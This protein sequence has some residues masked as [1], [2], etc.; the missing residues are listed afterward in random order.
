M[1]DRISASISSSRASTTSCNDYHAGGEFLVRTDEKIL[2]E[3]GYVYNMAGKPQKELSLDKGIFQDHFNIEV[4]K[5]IIDNPKEADEFFK[6]YG[7]DNISIYDKFCYYEE[8]LKKLKDEI[9]DKISDD[10]YKNLHKGLPFYLLSCYAF[11]MR[12]YEKALFYLDAA[13]SEDIKNSE[14][15]KICDKNYQN[16]PAYLFITL[17]EQHEASAIVKKIRSFLLKKLKDMH[18]INKDD[19]LNSFIE[20]LIKE[21]TGE[22]GKRSIITAFY[23]FLLE[24]KDLKEQLELRSEQGGS[25]EPFLLHLF[26]GGLIMESLLKLKYKFMDN[27]KQIKTLGDIFNCCKVFK[28]DFNFTP[29]TS[30]VGLDVILATALSKTALEDAFS[31]TAKLRNTTGHKLFWDDIF[32]DP[33][34]YEILFDNELKAICYIILEKKP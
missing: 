12:N 33:K 7:R 15:K 24:Y 14:N 31:I 1:S 27:G 28:D 32:D 9:K 19:E 4:L 30:A 13:I 16:D 10:G 20:K 6:T 25:I 17:K 22:E 34:N 26:K 11:D 21:K 5:K 3:N 23:T 18:L 2:T 29:E 8:L